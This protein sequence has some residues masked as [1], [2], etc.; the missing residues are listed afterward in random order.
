MGVSPAANAVKPGFRCVRTHSKP[1]FTA[2]WRAP[3]AQVTVLMVLMVLMVLIVL[4]ALVVPGPGSGF[5][6]LAVTA[7]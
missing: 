4:V 3:D 7:S 1:G 2:L 6:C 5:P